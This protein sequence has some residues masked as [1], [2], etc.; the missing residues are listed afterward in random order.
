MTAVQANGIT[1]E[2]ET[3]G[4][5]ENEAMLMV[6]GHNCQLVVWPPKMLEDLADAGFYVI[7][8]DNRDTGLS[9]WFPA[10]TQYTVSDMA[11]DGMGLLDALGIDA[12]HI[13]GVSLGGGIVQYMAIEY[14]E[15]VLSMCSIMSTTSAPGLPGPPPEIAAQAMQLLAT[16][17]TTREEIIEQ[18]VPKAHIVG[19]KAPFTIDEEMV[20]ERAA[21]AYDRAYN[22]D[23][24]INQT[25]A[26]AAA[27]DRTEALGK[28]T[29]P[30]VV[31]HG[32]VD[33][34]VHP[35]GGEWTAK[36]V[37]GAEL[38]IIEGMGHDLPD[39]AIPIV[40]EAIVRNAR[41]R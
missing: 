21:L 1:I 30:T 9:T 40:N 11:A 33:P 8:Y 5:P 7:A 17:A 3:W 6:M 12:A 39:G 2:Y 28:V 38:V 24:G 35:L 10:G 41:R 18:S 14:P 29:C 19:S 4:S 36:A 32:S 23:G 16:P 34:L 37:P 26:T 22:P 31:I 20:R 15:R 27:Y 13:V 25:L